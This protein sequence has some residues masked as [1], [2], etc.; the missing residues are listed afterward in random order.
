MK[1]YWQHAFYFPSPNPLPSE[2]A[3]KN[4]NIKKPTCNDDIALKNEEYS[5]VNLYFSFQLKLVK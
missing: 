5:D 2:G 3:F 1:Q 4:K